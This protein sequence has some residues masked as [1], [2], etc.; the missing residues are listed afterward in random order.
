MKIAFVGKGGSGKTTLTGLFAL[1][2][3]KSGQRVIAVDADINMNLGSILGAAID[4]EK[5]LG[6]A[7]NAERIQEYLRGDNQRI[8][9]SKFVNTT[10]PGLG[11]NIWQMASD[12]QTPMDELTVPFASGKGQLLV[13]G[14]YESE[15]LATGCYHGQLGVFENILSHTE[16]TADN[17]LIA[18]MVAGT[19]AFAGTL[20]AQ[21]DAV[22]V[23]IEPTP[24]GVGVARHY[25]SL[26]ATAGVA[27]TVNFIGNKVEDDNDRAYLERELP[28]TL[29]GYLPRMA[30]VKQ[31]RQEHSSLENVETDEISALM[32]KI[33]ERSHHSSK[34]EDERLSLLRQLH[35]RNTQQAWVR[36][37]FGDLTG[38]IDPEFTFAKAG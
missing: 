1:H 12:A 37:T 7:A 32:A 34:S 20:H 4:K 13:V 6:R 15:Q 14:S 31:R 33:E 16:T 8:D 23:V 36:N 25:Q 29:L 21:F 30:S 18:D 38:Q 17:W 19:D 28:G 11:S 9:V 35:E 5:F 3:A 22:F 24:E 10:P 27:H 2:V 26:A